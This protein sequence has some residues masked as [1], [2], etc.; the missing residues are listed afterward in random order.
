MDQKKNNKK[1]N[2]YDRFILWFCKAKIDQL[3]NSVSG[4]SYDFGYQQGFVQGCKVSLK[5]KNPKYIKKIE[6]L[7]KDG[8]YKTN[9]DK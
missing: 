7:I 3:L 8:K 1:I 9:F 6:R 5:G 4:Q 2:L